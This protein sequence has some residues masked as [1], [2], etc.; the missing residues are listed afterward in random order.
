MIE[1]FGRRR[2]PYFTPKD[3]RLVQISLDK[4]NIYKGP[5]IRPLVERANKH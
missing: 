3:K 2:N 1:R 5:I 4:E